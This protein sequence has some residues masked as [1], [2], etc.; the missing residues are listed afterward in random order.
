MKFTRTEKTLVASL[1]AAV[2]G[3]ALAVV[4]VS[5]PTAAVL[6]AVLLLAM[7]AI[8]WKPP[9]RD[10]AGRFTSAMLLFIG[11]AIVAGCTLFK[12]AP[13]AAPAA[14]PQAPGTIHFEKWMDTWSFFRPPYPTSQPTPA[15]V[16]TSREKTTVVQPENPKAA[17]TVR[18]EDGQTVATIP[19]AYEPPE[20]PG[21]PPTPSPADEALGGLV[22]LGGI[23]AAVGTALTAL[24]FIPGAAGGIFALVPAGLSVGIAGAG[25]LLL[26]FAETWAEMPTW[27]K[28]AAIVVVVGTAFA[29]AFRDNIKKAAEGLQAAK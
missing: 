24:R 26:A 29:V 21:L 1:A 3:L 9:R 5:M 2:V 23:L 10:A 15:T 25:A 12:Q 19:G 8:I 27:Q 11:P 20:P 4:S 17:A 22:W 18:Q 14:P 13:Q 6:S 16:T 28:I 7:L